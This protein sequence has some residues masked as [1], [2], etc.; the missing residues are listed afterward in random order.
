MI[1]VSKTYS[2]NINPTVL[3]TANLA[4][5]L[6]L[7]VHFLTFFIPNNTI[8]RTQDGYTNYSFVEKMFMATIP[9]INLIWGIKVYIVIDSSHFYFHLARC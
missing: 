8:N 1:D 7:L 5:S 4:L 3:I 2:H 6:G 9:N